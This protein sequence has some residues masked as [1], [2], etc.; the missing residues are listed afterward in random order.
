VRLTEQGRRL[1]RKLTPRAAA[2]SQV[3]MAPLTPEEQTRL[4]ALLTKLR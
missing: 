3:T 2:I 4:L 1:A